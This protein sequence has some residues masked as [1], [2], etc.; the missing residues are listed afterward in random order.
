MIAGQRPARR[1]ACLAAWIAW[2]ASS[3]APKPARA[4]D[5]DEC[6]RASE[7]AVAQRKQG[8]LIGARSALSACA[9]S[10]CP[11]VV[12]HSCQER[13]AEVS[14]VI[15]SVVFAVKDPSGRDVPHVTLFVDDAAAAER[16]G[17]ALE[18]D[19]GDHAF[20]FVTEAGA[21]TRIQLVLH[22]GERGRRETV[23][24]GHVAA[25]VGDAPLA[26]PAPPPATPRRAGGGGAVRIAGLVGT[27]VGV[28][29]LAV[30]GIFGGLSLAAHQNYEQHCGPRAGFAQG[31]CDATGYSGHADAVL[32]GNL[33][34]WFFV[35]GGVLTAAALAVT[36]LAAPGTPAVGLG[37]GSMTISAAF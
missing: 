32:K 8:H 22:E 35:G 31:I 20:R 24:L 17:G 26:A 13:L 9:A 10:S 18:L 34:T 30:G 27:G 16:V 28:A 11:D 7:Q 2:G 12:R 5:V 21:E 15:P 36:F 4:E 19:P 23:T 29:G 3:I 25:P 14:R 33:S 1:L 37:P 6:I